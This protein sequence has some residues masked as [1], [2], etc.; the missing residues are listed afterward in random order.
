MA[1][2]RKRGDSYRVELYKNGKRESETFPTKREASAWALQREAELTGRKLPYKLLS[3]ALEKYGTDIAPKHKGARWELVRCAKLATYPI[4][5]RALTAIEGPDVVEWRDDRLKEVGPASVA[6]EMNLLRSVFEACRTEWGWIKANPMADVKKPPTPTSRKRRVTQD[7]ADRI[8]LACGLDEDRA[9]TAMQRTGLAFLFA[10][11]T[12]MRAGEIVGLRW[13]EVAEKSVRLPETKNGDVRHVPLS[14]R[15]RVILSV[16][17]QTEGPVFGLDSGTRDV[18]F[19]RAR[20]AAN[21]PNLHFHD[22]RAEAIWRLS[23]K[24]DVLELA[25]VIGHR[26]L[27][28]LQLYYQI[29]ADELADRL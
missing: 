28:S 11:E 3:E 19:R 9:D 12:A 1:S 5:R 29:D 6:R 8:A 23:K 18:M 24:L 16:L 4:A 13:P 26:D 14:P 20:D 10:L 7:E 22:S 2:I 15:A 27:R 25:R 17:P 21:I